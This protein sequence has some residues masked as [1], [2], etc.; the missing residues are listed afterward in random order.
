[1]PQQTS[2]QWSESLREATRQALHEG[3]LTPDGRIHMK[4]IEGGF[5]WCRAVDVISGTFVLH[6]KGSE[7]SVSFLDAEAV[8]AAGWAID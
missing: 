7:Q 6:Y 1:M 8:V 2:K 4:Q 5:G 3:P